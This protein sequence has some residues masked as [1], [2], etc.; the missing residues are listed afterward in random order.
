MFLSM[1]CP[2][3]EMFMSLRC[4]S[5]WDVHVRKMFMSV[6]CSCPWDVQFFEKSMFLW[7]PCL[8]DIHVP[9]MSMSLRS[10]CPYL[11]LCHI[12]LKDL[13]E[14]LMDM[15]ISGT[16]PYQKLQHF[17]TMYISGTWTTLRQGQQCEMV[18]WLYQTHLVGLLRIWNI[19][20]LGCLM[21]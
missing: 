1:R 21:T 13:Y 18:F 4:P 12:Y 5:L 8:W 2:P 19:F 7:C 11:S 20:D 3:P 6:R 15:N 16:W 17:R 14:H 9:E 10:W